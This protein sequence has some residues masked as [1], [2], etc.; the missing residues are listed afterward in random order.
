MG[1]G[2]R[3]DGFVTDSAG[4]SGNALNDEPRVKKEKEGKKKKAADAELI[5]RAD[6]WGSLQGGGQESFPLPQS[7]ISYL[8]LTSL[9]TCCW[10]ICDGFLK[11]KPLG[12]RAVYAPD[13][14]HPK[15]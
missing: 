1:G 3:R 12:L 4:L 10:D 5:V 9:I 6:P 8:F 14:T 13:Q 15:Y 11:P 7:Q 2:E